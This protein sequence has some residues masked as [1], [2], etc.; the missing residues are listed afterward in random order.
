MTGGAK[1]APRRL[2]AVTIDEKRF[3][4]AR[5]RQ[6]SGMARNT[7]AAEDEAAP[8]EPGASTSNSA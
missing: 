3:L 5:K 1:P 6:V 7:A 2:V 4:L 8:Q